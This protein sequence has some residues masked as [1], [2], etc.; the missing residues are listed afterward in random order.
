MTILEFISLPNDQ[1]D[2]NLNC[3]GSFIGERRQGLDRFFLYALGHFYV[4]LKLIYSEK[5]E[6]ILI[7]NLVFHETKWLEPYM[8]KIDISSL[9]AEF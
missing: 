1:Q 4:E 9:I 7:L 8:E 2:K 5:G 3:Y 6:S